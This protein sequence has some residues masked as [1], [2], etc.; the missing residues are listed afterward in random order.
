MGNIE[1]VVTAGIVVDGL[2]AL[3][4]IWSVEVR[5]CGVVIVVV[6]VVV[7]VEVEAAAEPASAADDGAAV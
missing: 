7:T 6:V 2:M 1:V 3:L 4:L 5:S